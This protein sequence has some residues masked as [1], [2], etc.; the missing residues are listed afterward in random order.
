[1][2]EVGDGS[3]FRLTKWAIQITEENVD[4]FRKLE[5]YTTR[6]RENRVKALSD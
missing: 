1:M 5:R 2:Y 4:S 3:Y 6:Y